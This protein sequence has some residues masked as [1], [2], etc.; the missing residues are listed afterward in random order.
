MACNDSSSAFVIMLVPS[1]SKALRDSFRLRVSEA[2]SPNI[3][4][5]LILS[6]TVPLERIFAGILTRNVQKY[7][8]VHGTFPCS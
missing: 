7:S 6:F 5:A 1:S 8:M 2:V 3:E 4:S